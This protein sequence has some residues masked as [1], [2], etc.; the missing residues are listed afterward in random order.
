MR[1][2]FLFIVFALGILLGV[3]WYFDVE[4]SGDTFSDIVQDP[5][6]AVQSLWERL[7]LWV[8]GLYQKAISAAGGT[9]DARALAAA[10]IAG[11]ETFSPKAYPDPP[12]QYNRYAIGYGHQIVP[13]DGF[14]PQ[15]VISEPDAL[16]LLH[17][18]LDNKV[19]CVDGAV[20]VPCTP[21]Q[22]AAL[23]SL[24][25]NIGCE[26]F[27]NSTLVRELNNGNYDGAQAEFA[28]WNHAGGV[29]LTALTDRRTAEADFF[30][31]GGS[32]S[33]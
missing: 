1:R 16:A 28:R 12:G 7:S 29:T 3:V 14:T 27:A 13:G 30:A 10:L 21:Q 2:A 4:Q 6:G 26:A 24:T 31:S 22:T 25:F 9:A 33:A 18:D 17:A 5:V 19:A 20:T 15:S 23:Y 11:F 8:N 32:V